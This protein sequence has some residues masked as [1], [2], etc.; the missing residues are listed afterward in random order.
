MDQEQTITEAPEAS[1]APDQSFVVEGDMVS[2]VEKAALPTPTSQTGEQNTDVVEDEVSA[3]DTED[4]AA[5]VEAKPV[6]DEPADRLDKHP[7]FQELIREKNELKQKL[8]ELDARV[9][10]GAKPPEPVKPAYEDLSTLGDEDIL[11]KFNEDPKG[12]LAN[13]AKQVH[14]EVKN[15]LMQQQDLRDQERQAQLQEQQTRSTFEKY[16]KENTDFLEM[17]NNGDIPKFMEDNPGHNAISAH[18]LMTAQKRID[19]AV[20]TAVKEAEERVTKN[21]QLKRTN[22]VLGSTAATPGRGVPRVPPELKDPKAY[23][24]V[25]TVLAQRLA[26]RKAQRG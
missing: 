5:K 18:Q 24:G 4:A 3:G 26:A 17:W 23:G 8:A 19:E 20:Q 1:S 11:N 15:D 22:A 13:F 2:T 7:R 10:T 9:T 16:S 25:T 21:Y 12:F 6:K 14:A